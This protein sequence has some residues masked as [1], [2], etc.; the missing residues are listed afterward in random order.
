MTQEEKIK[1]WIRIADEDLVVAQG[2]LKMKHYL[3][4]GFMCQQAVEKILKGYFTKIKDEVPPFIHD[5]LKIAKKSEIYE[6]LSEEQILLLGDLEPFYI[7]ARY[8]D[9]KMKI[10]KSLTKDITKS[11]LERTKEFVLWTKEKM[12]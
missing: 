9:Y 5:L 11:I 4:A 2:M 12:Q 3:Y 1:H 6:L 10:A 7:E 8:N